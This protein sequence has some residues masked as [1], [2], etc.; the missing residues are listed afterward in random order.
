[1]RTNGSQDQNCCL[2]HLV[3]QWYCFWTSGFHVT[4]SRIVTP[5]F[6][7][8]SFFLTI[9]LVEVSIDLS[10]KIPSRWQL[11]RIPR[12][13]PWWCKSALVASHFDP[14]WHRIEYHPWNT[15]R[16]DHPRAPWH[17]RDICKSPEKCHAVGAGFLAAPNPFAGNKCCWM[18]EFCKK[19]CCVSIHQK[20]TALWWFFIFCH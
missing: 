13:Q 17:R 8:R 7:V 4:T 6:K 11:L 10:S 19:Y 15:P 9:R 14:R 5:N 20:N 12:S 1:M 18:W 2:Q 3:N 16:L